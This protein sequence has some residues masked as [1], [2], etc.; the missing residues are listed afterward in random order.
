M[1][2]LKSQIANQNQCR[3]LFANRVS[4]CTK[5]KFMWQEGAVIE[6]LL[7]RF[8]KSKSFYTISQIMRGSRN[9]KYLYRS[10]INYFLKIKW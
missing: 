7:T 2:E 3:A 4:D 1:S 9:N 8:Q 5:Q 6:V 10:K